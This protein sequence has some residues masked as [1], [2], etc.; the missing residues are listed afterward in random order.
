[1]ELREPVRC[2]ANLVR[3]RTQLK[4]RIHACLLMNNVKIEA[5]PFT[6][7]F[8]RELAKI[9]DYRVQGYLRLIASVNAE[10]KEASK[11]IMEKAANDED[12][13]LLMTI[14]GISFYWPCSYLAR[15]G[16]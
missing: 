5:K 15:S 4:N 6:E 14:P 7:V 13:K 11:H 16:R 3:Q 2:R 10:V 12:A 8:V 1:M 9:D